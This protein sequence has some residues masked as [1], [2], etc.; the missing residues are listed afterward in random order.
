MALVLKEGANFVSSTS[1]DSYQQGY[2]RISSIQ[3]NRDSRT[4]MIYL[5]IYL[6]KEQSVAKIEPPIDFRALSVPSEDFNIWFDL[7]VLESSENIFKQMYGYL[8]Q[9]RGIYPETLMFGDWEPDI[10]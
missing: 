8:V 7:P 3:Y 2:L 6:S 10:T 9:K 5:S 4:M 1:N